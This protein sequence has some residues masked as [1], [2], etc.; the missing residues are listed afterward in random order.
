MNDIQT[1]DKNI[2]LDKLQSTIG[3]YL[4]FL[5]YTPNIKIEDK[6]FFLFF[7]IAKNHIFYD[8][9]KR[10]AFISSLLLGNTLDLVAN[11]QHDNYSIS[12]EPILVKIIEEGA[13]KCEV[14]DSNY[15]NLQKIFFDNFLFKRISKHNL[16]EKE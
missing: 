10:C 6:V 9:N 7:R 8:G 15:H 13:G 4:N 14:G 12:I 5:L 2:N 16:I 3:A 1:F 11:N